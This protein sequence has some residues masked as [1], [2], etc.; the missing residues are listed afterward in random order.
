MKIMITGAGGMLGK[1]LSSCLE[2]REHKVQGYPRESLDVTNFHQ[3]MDVMTADAPDLVIHAAAY[4]KVDQAESEPELAYMINGYGSENISVACNRLDIPMVYISSDYVFDGEHNRPY[5]PWDQTGPLS[6][7]GK[8]K[9]AGERAVRN[10]LNKFYI[11]RTSWLYGPDGR[12]FVDTIH[13]MAVDGKPLRVVSDQFGSP[14]C[15]LTLSETIADLIMTKRWGI[16]HATDSGVTNWHEFALEIVKGM[17]VTVQPIATKDM[18]RPATRPKYSVLDKT[19][20]IHTIERELVPW[21]EALHM[22][23]SMKREKQAV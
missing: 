17:K 12:N 5:Q 10:H 19:T 16:Y 8:T 15:T 13:Q 18:P 22:Y 11:V 1:A 23:L 9:L 4:T 20:L 6:V 3:V 2:S 7:Y 14:T 21:K